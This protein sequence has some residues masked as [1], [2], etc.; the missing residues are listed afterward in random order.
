ML[1]IIFNLLIF[2]LY[3]LRVL[4]GN[5]AKTARFVQDHL[6]SQWFINCEVLFALDI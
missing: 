3:N 2:I 4:N 1:S 5:L 6:T